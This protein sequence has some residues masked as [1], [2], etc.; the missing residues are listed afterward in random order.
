MGDLH[1]L[2]EIQR[3][4]DVTNRDWQRIIL[5][6]IGKSLGWDMLT[7][8]DGSLGS[9]K[10]K[11]VSPTDPSNVLETRQLWWHVHNKLKSPEYSNMLLLV[12]MQEA[13]ETIMHDQKR[14]FTTKFA[15]EGLINKI[16]LDTAGS[17]V[18][19][20]VELSD[21]Q[22]REERQKAWYDSFAMDIDE[23]EEAH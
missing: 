4:R 6:N 15:F 23:L 19:P 13:L 9:C 8:P 5:R 17:V 22:A 11:P 14:K 2:Q 20:F 10:S 12:R 1:R 21:S 18:E 16:H 7:M 3:K